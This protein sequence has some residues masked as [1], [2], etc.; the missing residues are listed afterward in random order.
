MQR[1]MPLQ[2]TLY[3]TIGV[4]V[5][6]G[7]FVRQ[8]HVTQ[9]LL[10]DASFRV[11]LLLG[12]IA[13]LVGN[14]KQDA[15][16]NTRSLL[17]IVC[18]HLIYLSQTTVPRLH[19][20]DPALSMTRETRQARLLQLSMKNPQT[21][22]EQIAKRIQFLVPSMFLATPATGLSSTLEPACVHFVMEALLH[23]SAVCCDSIY[24][25]G[26]FLLHRCKKF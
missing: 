6:M 10:E 14:I 19:S 1:P 7:T 11:L 21:P 3:E 4:F 8:T 26:T 25:G 5:V 24:A 17:D 13:K 9:K 18:L 15:K 20:K 23:P 12:M 2:R 22:A 16:T